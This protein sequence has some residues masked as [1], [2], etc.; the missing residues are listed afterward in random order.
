MSGWQYLDV[1][2]ALGPKRIEHERPLE[3]RPQ[4]AGGA[5]AFASV[6][7]FVVR[8]GPL[9]DLGGVELGDDARRSPMIQ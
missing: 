1:L 9:R 2:A 5:Q 4:I 7:G 3:L 6:F 8:G